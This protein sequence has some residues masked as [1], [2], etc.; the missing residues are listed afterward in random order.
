MNKAPSSPFQVWS[1]TLTG[2]HDKDSLC[3]QA[4][5]FVW[6]MWFP[7]WPFPRL[8]Y[9]MVYS[10]TPSFIPMQKAW[11]GCTGLLYNNTAG[12]LLFTTQKLTWSK[13]TIVVNIRR[14]VLHVASC[15]QLNRQIQEF[16]FFF[17]RVCTVI[18]LVNFDY[19]CDSEVVQYNLL[20]IFSSYQ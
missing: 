12:L 20:L 9:T 5:L 11:V 8:P 17:R 6:N 14:C 16:Y 3:W 1:F 19:F 10:H 7:E 2:N 18:S 13:E 4:L 15:I